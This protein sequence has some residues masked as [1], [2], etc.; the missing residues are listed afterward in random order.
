[1]DMAGH[2]LEPCQEP[3]RPCHYRDG[4]TGQEELPGLAIL[5]PWFMMVAI[6]A[7]L[8]YNTLLRPQASSQGTRR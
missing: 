8:E 4:P 1:L 7:L 3:A 2:M 6:N 5:L